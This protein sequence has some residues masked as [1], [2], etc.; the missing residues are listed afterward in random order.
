MMVWEGELFR[1][2]NGEISEDEFIKRVTATWEGLT[3]QI[4]RR[5]QIQ[6][7]R[8]TIG[9]PPK[10]FAEEVEVTE[11]GRIAF[12]V[13]AGVFA[14]MCILLIFFVYFHSNLKVVEICFSIFLVCLSD[15]CDYCVYWDYAYVCVSQYWNLYFCVVVVCGWYGHDFGQHFRQDLSNLATF[16]SSKEVFHCENERYRSSPYLVCCCL[17]CDYHSCCLDRNG[18]S[19]CS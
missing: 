15:W 1:L 13:V 11:A 12:A 18:R 2:N 19:N 10:D 6:Q 17:L 8:A 3:D 14:L 9:L 16:P 5:D 7:Y 4:G